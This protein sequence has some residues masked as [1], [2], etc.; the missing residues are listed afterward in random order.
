[1]LLQIRKGEWSTPAIS[2]AQPNHGSCVNKKYAHENGWRC[3]DGKS[4]FANQIKLFDEL[5]ERNHWGWAARLNMDLCVFNK[6]RDPKM[7]VENLGQWN[8][9]AMSVLVLDGKHSEFSNLV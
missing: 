5:K 3:T 8:E 1:M 4:H 6:L 9:R 2:G 7:Y